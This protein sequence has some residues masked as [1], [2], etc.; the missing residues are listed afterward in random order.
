[1]KIVDLDP[2]D[3]KIIRQVAELLVLAFKEHWPNAW[4]DIE[5]ATQEIMDSFGEDRISRVAITNKGRAVGWIGGIPEYEGFTWELHPLAVH[6]E[7][8]GQG[9]GHAL[10]TNLENEV[11][12][13][14]GTTIYLG[15]DDERG[16]T[17]LSNVDL[18]PNVFEHIARIKN[19]L[20]HPYSFYQKMGY[21]IV[22]VIPDAN[23]LGKPDIIMAKRV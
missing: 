22:G 6:P 15:T 16:M 14:G 9:I 21:V 18:Y 17:S 4:P 3:L 20:G 2:K 12:Q 8:Q 23:G 11:R 13:R 5:F 7:Y 19:L 10:V 1:L